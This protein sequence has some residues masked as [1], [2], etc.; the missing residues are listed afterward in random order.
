M[1]KY[2]FKL[3]RNTGN[4]RN[5]KVMIYKRNYKLLK[6]VSKYKK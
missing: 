1:K 3:K 5:K 2:S 4:A 6:E